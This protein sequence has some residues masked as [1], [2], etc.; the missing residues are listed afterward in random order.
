VAGSPAPTVAVDLQNF[1]T[2]EIWLQGN[3]VTYAING[4][5]VYSGAA[6]L[7]SSNILVIGDGSGSD[8]SG[9]GS[10]HVDWVRIRSGSDYA[11]APGIPSAV[12]EPGTLAGAGMA[13]VLVATRY[14]ARS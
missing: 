13:L 10:M 2:Y 11:G 7:S 6:A 14:L 5:Q 3:T 4:V 1:N 9:I 8:I 12:P